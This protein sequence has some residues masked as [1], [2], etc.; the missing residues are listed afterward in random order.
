V[1]AGRA[2]Q[3]V[4]PQSAAGKIHIADVVIGERH[5]KDLGDLEQLAAS[6]RAQGL[7][8][9]IGVTQDKVLVF[10]ERRLRACAGI[11]GW[12]E[13]DARIVNVTSIAAGEHDEDEVRKAF[14]VSERVAI[15]ETI[16]AEVERH[17]GA[18]TD[19]GQKIGRSG[20]VAD[21]AAR[22]AGFGNRETAR[23]AKTVVEHGAPE[24]VEAVDNG[25]IAVSAAA[26]IA[27]LP[28]DEQA[29]I[30]ANADPRVVL[31]AAKAALAVARAEAHK[32]KAE[33]RQSK[34]RELAA[35]I[36]SLPDAKYGVILADPE[37]DFKCWS[38]KTNCSAAYHYATS[39]LDEIK[40][41][42]VPSISAD[43]C[44]LFLWAT[45]PM[46][47]HALEVMAAWGFIYKSQFV[48][49]KDRT[50]TGY[51]NWNKHEL[52]LIGTR[53]KV[54]APAP[55]SQW[56]SAVEAPVGG[57]SV[58][59]G[60]FHELIEAYFPNLP[61]IELNARKA[62]PGWDVWGA[63]ASPAVDMPLPAVV[64]PLACRA[65][66]RDADRRHH[67]ARPTAHAS[68][69][70]PRGASRTCSTC[71]AERGEGLRRRSRRVR[72]NR[73]QDRQ[74]LNPRRFQP[75]DGDPTCPR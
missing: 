5:R 52:L 9:P 64:A 60:I 39:T 32:E 42:D 48:W 23:Q 54:P 10:G 2:P 61:R 13:I 35:K 12:T 49:I 50:G 6:I 18:R 68:G 57:H 36:T 25:E 45:V 70:H 28:A 47:P 22:L 63:E 59:P 66:I 43:D 17:Q 33:R 73:C 74:P 3:T 37:W 58:K 11:L 34:E 38:E 29:A 62:R 67:R 27:S 46:M 51:W 16:S 7:L 40:A 4:E 72:A 53:G 44:V 56:P 71:R 26:A 21:E 20:R 14:T 55:G 19:L 31:K 1:I 75:R 69:A 30:V 8:Q 24:L 15:L 65:R 41:R